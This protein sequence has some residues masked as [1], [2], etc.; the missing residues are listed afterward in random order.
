VPRI[1]IVDD[2]KDVHYSFK[3]MLRQQTGLNLISAH[4][5]E[6]ALTLL[7]NDPDVDLIIMDIRMGGISGLEVLKRLRNKEA[8]RQP[9]VIIMT[10]FS[11]ADVAIEATKLGA[12]DYVIKP[13]DVEK[14][15]GL[16]DE[17]LHAR[18]AMSRVVRLEDN[19]QESSAAD[20]DAI[21]GRHRSMQEVYKLIGRVAPTDATVLIQGESGTGKELVARAIYQH[22]LR[23]EKIFLPI[24]CAA[25]PESLLESELFGHERGAFTGAVERRLGKFEQCDG[26]TLF[27]DEIGDFSP[28][29]QA[30]ILRLLEDSSFQRLGGDRW[31]TTDVRILAATH[32]DLQ[33]MVQE[34][35]FRE[36]LYYRL[37]VVSIHLP[38]L[39][40]RREDIT[41]L[42]QFFMRRYA[43]QYGKELKGV[44]EEAIIEL[45]RFSWPGNVRQL[46]NAVRRAIVVARGDL[47]MPEDFLL[48]DGEK[49][50]IGLEPGPRGEETEEILAHRVE[51]FLD[52]V[53]QELAHAELS[54]GML[55]L[56]E[57]IMIQKAVE[58]TDGNQ[59][60]AS[61]LLG[62][63]RNTLR[64]RL[65]EMNQEEKKTEN[66]A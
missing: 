61:K 47:L 24:N 33:S 1:L 44:S 50:P 53:F 35:K 66:N 55:P 64:S 14:M 59:V 38:P 40:Q 46:Q 25:I 15:K 28:A 20:E 63:S 21:I 48:P 12:Y 13:F 51:P 19:L 26:G 22:S 34:G 10:A 49:S 41:D 54:H 9:I 31:I 23:K 27:L 8:S 60:H 43:A 58:F 7:E 57:K 3:R 52:S 65:K 42:V 62:L 4:S 11:T 18:A 2:E 29:L 45:Q 17:A 37:N 32:R 30:K 6:E 39:R 36:D 5:G 56:I 16:V